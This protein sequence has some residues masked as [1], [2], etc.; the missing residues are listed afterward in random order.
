MN[1]SLLL[2]IVMLFVGMVFLILMFSFRMNLAL[3]QLSFQF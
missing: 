2:A 1:V 3:V